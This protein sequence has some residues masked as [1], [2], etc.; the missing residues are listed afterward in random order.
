[1][2]HDI[3]I[4][5]RELHKVDAEQPSLASAAGPESDYEDEEEVV[6]F[7]AG[8]ASPTTSRRSATNPESPAPTKA[9]A[10]VNGT[11]QWRESVKTACKNV[12]KRS[13]LSN[14][15]SV[16]DCCV[17]CEK[18]TNTRFSP[19]SRSP[20]ERSPAIFC[21]GLQLSLGGDQ[22]FCD[23]G[24]SNRIPEFTTR[25][26]GENTPKYIVTLVSMRG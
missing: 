10:T 7:G 21:D 24:I 8:A 12:G 13:F 23:V 25:K 18:D 17:G 4:G 6:G 9:D 22:R 20:S 3:L 1:M 14:L 26:W 15:I 2:R 16:V 11:V 19:I 5:V